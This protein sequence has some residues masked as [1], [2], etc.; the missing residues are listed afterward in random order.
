MGSGQSLQNPFLGALRNERR[1]VAVYL[2]NG[3]KLEGE[4]LS[5][6]RFVVQ[7]RCRSTD[8][9]VYKHTIAAIVPARSVM[10]SDAGEKAGAV[11]NSAV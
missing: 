6:D 10:L 11:E 5:F 1:R 2:L 7:L 3:I 8:S 4:I 9:V